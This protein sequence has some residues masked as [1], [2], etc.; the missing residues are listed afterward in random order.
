MTGTYRGYDTIFKGESVL[1]PSD[2][3]AGTF[4]PG[5][6]F[7]RLVQITPGMDK[8]KLAH[9]GEFCNTDADGELH[10]RAKMQVIILDSRPRSTRFEDK[11]VACRSY[12][13]VTGPDGQP[14]RGGCAYFAFKKNDIPP[15]EK[16]KGSVVLLC[17]D[18]EEPGGD[19]Y[20]VEFSA[21]GIAD[22]REYASWLQD[23][24]HRPVFACTTTID[25]MTRK[26]GG[27]EPYVPVFHPVT[28]LDA[29]TL[30]LMRER[31]VRERHHLDAP[32][33]M[34]VHVPAETTE[35]TEDY[36]GYVPEE[37]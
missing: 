25:S 26:Q 6:P 9:A 7:W 31:R 37:E 2:R 36:E 14:C 21:S 17:V 16:C 24:K 28:A 35:A 18:A 20:C 13:G 10:F 3:V 29:V 23:R 1:D 15:Q 11:R 30:A 27:G 5:L 22:W 4:A 32:D 34:P 19:P 8:A 33:A 12:D